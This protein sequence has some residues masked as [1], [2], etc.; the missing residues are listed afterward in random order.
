MNDK[1]NNA[2]KIKTCVLV[3]LI[4]VSGYCYAYDWTAKDNDALRADM[5]EFA[6]QFALDVK[7]TKAETVLNRFIRKQEKLA[8]TSDVA[9]MDATLEVVNQLTELYPPVV[10]GDN[11]QSVIRRRILQLLDYPLHVDNKGI[12][13]AKPLAT[14]EQ[15]RAFSDLCDKYKFHARQKFLK[16]LKSP[17]PEE[18]KLDLFKIYNMGFVIRTANH[19]LAIDV[20]WEGTD[21]EAKLIAENV[22]IFLLTHAHAD[23]FSKSLLNAM[24]QAD[25]PIV[26]SEDILPSYSSDKKIVVKGDIIDPLD[27]GGIKV[28]TLLGYQ[29]PTPCNIFMIELDG[30]RFVDNGDNND[31]ERE[32]R[33]KDFPAY[34]FVITAAWN[35]VTNI[36]GAAMQANN[37]DGRK[38]LYIPAHE[39]ELGHPVDHRESYHETYARKDRLGDPDFNYPE[40]VLLNIGESFILT[41]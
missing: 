30:W 25:K 36:L 12:A 13:P 20:R 9:W 6:K 22:D 5:L 41:K 8:K 29:Y 24:A 33:I 26:L 21:D 3:L 40:H 19:S 38:L 28:A 16:W 31:L 7:G 11:M 15:K 14:D 23:H 39:N 35:S 32:R 17:R 27:I 18:G 1:R 34:D 10:D 2:M 37:E 4:F